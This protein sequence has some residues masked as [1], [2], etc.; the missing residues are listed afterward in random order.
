MRW[1]KRASWEDLPFIALIDV[2]T[3]C[4]EAMENLLNNREFPEIV[5]IYIQIISTKQFKRFKAFH[6]YIKPI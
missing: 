1:I 5:E 6:Y 3:T 4:L 2:E